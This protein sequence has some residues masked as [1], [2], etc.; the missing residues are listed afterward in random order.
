MKATDASL[1]AQQALQRYYRLHASIYDATRWSFLLGRNQALRLV[2]AEQPARVLEVGCGTGR[3]LAS[4]AHLLPGTALTGVDL[5]A[6]MLERAQR[7]LACRATLLQQAYDQPV[8]RAGEAFDAVLC[9]YALTMFNPG[10]ETALRCAYEDLRPGGRLVVVDFYDTRQPWFRH[11]MK[12][13][14]VRMDGQLH[15]R[16]RQLFRPEVDRFLPAYAGLW[17]YFVFVGQKC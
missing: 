2:A 4:L 10:W 15:P 11:W 8:S 1:S 5:S 17:R 7:R 14:H 12:H 9:S 6:T 13:N 16:L 3:N